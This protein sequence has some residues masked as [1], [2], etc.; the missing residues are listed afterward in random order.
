MNPQNDFDASGSAS[1][2]NSTTHAS[3]TPPGVEALALEIERNPEIQAALSLSN[4][5]SEKE[6][7]LIG[8][9]GILPNGL[10]DG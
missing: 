7:H 2:P 3:G 10:V 4:G 8:G 1:E 6:R 9:Q 5:G